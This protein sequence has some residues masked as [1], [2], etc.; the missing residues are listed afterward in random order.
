MLQCVEKC[1]IFI[2][3]GRM[4]EWHVQ[5]CVRQPHFAGCLSSTYWLFRYK[6]SISFG[7]VRHW[8]TAVA[9]ISIVSTPLQLITSTIP[10]QT[11]GTKC[12]LFRLSKLWTWHFL[13]C[14]VAPKNYG[15]RDHEMWL[16]WNSVDLPL[17]T[18]TPRSH[19]T[20]RCP[21]GSCV[22]NSISES[23]LYL[24]ERLINRMENYLQ[25]Y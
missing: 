4:G 12:S 9:I 11:H 19:F 25:L 16:R 24:S 5:L 1:L 6:I 2:D 8:E 20:I 10:R 21:A 23:P 17:G 22:L 15:V 18:T 7:S 13:L 3:I 14:Y